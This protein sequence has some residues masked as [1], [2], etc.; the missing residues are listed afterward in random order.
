MPANAASIPATIDPA[1]VFEREDA[2]RIVRHS[3]HSLRRWERAGLIPH[4]RLPNGRVIYLRSQITEWLRS[5]AVS[6]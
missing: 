3:P 1:D 2:A 6:A 5:K 4:I